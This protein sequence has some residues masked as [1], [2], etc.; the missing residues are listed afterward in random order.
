MKKNNVILIGMP[1]AGK[2]T[3][4][5]LLAKTLKMPFLDTDLLIQQREG[6]FLQD[7]I[8]QDGIEKF[9]AIEENAILSLRVENHVVATGGSVIYSAAA[10]NYLKA[11]GMLVYLKLRYY[12]V[13]KRIRNIRTRGVAMNKGQSFWDLYN[14]RVPLYEKH[15][16]IVVN[17]S[18]KHP[19][20][21]VEE[22]EELVLKKFIKDV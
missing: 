7:I 8:N 14:E 19:E 1:G 5:V 21:V 15:A 12:E 9:L 4:G 11:C 13:E 6:R 2:S 16:E 22:I 17:C 18:R 20:K 3:I 10:V